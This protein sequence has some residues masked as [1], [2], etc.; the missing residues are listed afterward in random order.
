MRERRKQV[1]RI[2]NQYIENDHHIFT[3]RA[4]KYAVIHS[5]LEAMERT[6][7]LGD[8]R[9]AYILKLQDAKDH[10][11]LLEVMHEIFAALTE[12]QSNRQKNSRDGCIPRAK[13][14]IEQHFEDPM[15]GLYSISEQL[16]I[17]NT[18]LSMAFKKQYG[19]G[20]AQY[21][22]YLRVEKAKKMMV[23]TEYSIK[24]IAFRVG[25]TSDMTFIRVFKQFEHIT[26]GKY[27]KDGL[28][29]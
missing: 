22:N 19:L 2:F 1:D 6:P 4:K 17:S 18:Y 10:R 5:L 28:G 20:V 25:F 11:M 21:I 7:E 27:K 15:I 29:I 26:P 13:E 16:G 3:A 12:V 8:E 14:Y 24:E 23:N 9:E